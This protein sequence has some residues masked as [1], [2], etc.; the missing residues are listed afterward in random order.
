MLAGNINRIRRYKLRKR[1]NPTLQRHMQEPTVS[2]P[3]CLPSTWQTQ[4]YNEVPSTMES[5]P[6]LT[7]TLY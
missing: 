1:G 7:P 4:L 6:L 2:S 3:A 5:N